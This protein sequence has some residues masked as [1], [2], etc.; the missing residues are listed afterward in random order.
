[1]N[2]KAAS[3]E[4]GPEQEKG[5]QQAQAALQAVLSLGPQNPAHPMV[6]EVSVADGDTG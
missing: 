6:L 2:R 4:G 1:M 5:L 3:L